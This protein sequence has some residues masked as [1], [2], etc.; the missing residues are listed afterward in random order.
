[1]KKIAILFAA[2]MTAFSFVSCNKEVVPEEKPVKQTIKFNITVSDPMAGTRA[3]KKGWE[4]GDVIYVWLEG[5]TVAATPDFT[6]TYGNDSWSA[7]ELREGVTLEDGKKLVALYSSYNDMTV[8]AGASNLLSI[9]TETIGSV[10]AYASPLFIY[11]SGLTYHFDGTS[12]TATLDTWLFASDLQVVVSGLDPSL[13]YAL[14]MSSTVGVTSKGSVY[15]D[16]ISM[17]SEEFYAKGLENSDGKAFYFHKYRPSTSA[18]KVTFTLY[19]SDG[20]VYNYT[21]SVRFTGAGVFQAAKISFSKFEIEGYIN[22]HEY[23]DMGAAGKWATMNIGAETETDYGDYYAW[24][25]TKTRNYYSDENYTYE[26]N[27]SI[28]PLSD[29]VANLKWGGSWR[30]P[31]K[32]EW[33]ELLSNCTY[34]WK[35]NYNESG[36]NGYLFTCESN[37]NKLFL[38][39][40]GY[41]YPGGGPASAGTYGT[42]WSSSI[43][44][45]NMSNAWSMDFRSVSAY[46]TSGERWYGLPV[47]PIVGE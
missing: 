42:Y 20:T 14:E 45:S 12:V 30:M 44:G 39:A 38:P 21:T 31:T 37:S 18:T 32:A 24:G 43:D 15:S 33:D 26:M 22:G 35:E 29:D 2:M 17:T 6:L 19:A 27:P 7:S 34:V 40:A 13:D 10:T 47:R 28:L 5:N 8:L 1:M 36:K 23:V 9:P 11:T 25:E 46:T 3:V 4:T 16:M 41:K